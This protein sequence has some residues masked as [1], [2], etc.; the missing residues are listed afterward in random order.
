MDGV[1]ARNASSTARP[2]IAPPQGPPPPPTQREGRGGSPRPHEPRVCRGSSAARSPA[3]IIEH[4]GST[5]PRAR[6]GPCGMP[7]LSPRPCAPTSNASTWASAA[8]KKSSSTDEGARRGMRL[9]QLQLSRVSCSEQRGRAP[10]PQARRR[11]PFRGSRPTGPPYPRSSTPGPPPRSRIRPRRVM[12]RA[13]SFSPHSDPNALLR[14]S[15]RSD[16]T[17]SS[18]FFLAR[19]PHTRHRTPILDAITRVTNDPKVF[20]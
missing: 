5:G 12:T 16:T 14:R 6:R 2:A 7:C 19:V 10:R 20:V 4:S 18:L 1:G 13:V 3:G 15:L 17:Q 8:Q 9:H 11:V